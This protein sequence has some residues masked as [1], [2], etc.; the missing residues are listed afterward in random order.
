MKKMPEGAGPAGLASGRTRQEQGRNNMK[1]ISSATMTTFMVTFLYLSSFM[2][3]R[4][5]ERLL[6]LGRYCVITH[7]CSVWKKDFE[8]VGTC[9]E[10]IERSRSA[11]YDFIS[12]E[13]IRCVNAARWAGGED[14]L[15]RDRCAL[16][17]FRLHLRCR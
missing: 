5:P 4:P 9:V 10:Q 1:R 14:G 12:D 3:C 6:D 17:R 7:N 15:F 11:G 2:G 8:S 16:P 13:E